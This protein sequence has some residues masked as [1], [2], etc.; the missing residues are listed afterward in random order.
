MKGP[1]LIISFLTALIF[2][3]SP[4]KAAEQ[5]CSDTSARTLRVAFYPFVPDVSDAAFRIKQLFED[6]CPGLDLQLI[7]DP[8]Y[9]SSEK[10]KGIL[11][12]K[13]DV[14]EVD[15]V[16]FTD[17]LQRKKAQPLTQEIVAAAGPVVPMARAI[18]VQGETTFGVP[19]WLC[20]DFLVYRKDHPEIGTIKVFS[21]AKRVFSGSNK[22]LIDLK[23][24]STL[25]ELYLAIVAAHYGFDHISEHLASI[26]DYALQRLSELLALDPSGFGR[27]TDYHYRDGFY[28][29]QFARGAGAGFVGYSET[30]HYVLSEATQS[31]KHGECLNAAGLD[32]TVLPF[33]D[34]GAK[35]VAWVDMYMIDA[36]ASGATLRDA[37]A[38]VSFMMKPATY[39]ALLLPDNNV[40]R[41]L[42]PARADL[43]ANPTMIQNAPLYA[44]F[45]PIIDTATPVTAPVLNDN[46]RKIG[47]DIDAKL[48]GSH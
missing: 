17:F 34:N 14:Y 20:T 24:S 5:Y 38:F 4:A 2:A 26:D 18:P 41:Y 19:H 46:L 43:Y 16:F 8:D 35:P 30:T 21:D 40:P 47:K 22:L 37:Q 11:Y 13:A 33:G 39:E 12:T 23:G 32:V 29:K 48:P 3:C 28:Q 31:C 6:G 15:S 44:K 45:K 25:G 36:D 27:D 9:Y 1:T 42:L 7:I 10:Q